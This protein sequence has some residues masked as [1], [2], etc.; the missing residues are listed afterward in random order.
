MSLPMSGTG[1]WYTVQY[2]G[3]AA[4]LPFCSESGQ[5]K[6]PVRNVPDPDPLGPITVLDGF[7]DTDP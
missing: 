7:P 4:T 6:A 5:V 1:G 2:T 3:H